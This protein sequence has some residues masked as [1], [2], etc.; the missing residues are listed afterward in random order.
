MVGCDLGQAAVFA[1]IATLP[2]FGVLIGLAAV[3]CVLQTAYGPAR[4]AAVPMLVEE[5]ELISANALL[6]AAS[7]L[8]VAAGP[9][10]GGILFATVGAPT[11]LLV[12]VATFIG[13]ALL[14]RTLP[15]I[16]P[17]ET[18]ERESLLGATATGGRFVWADPVLRA[19]AVS[20]CLLLAFLAVDNV[21]LVF[22]VRDTLSG[23]AAAYGAIEFCWGVGMLIGSFWVLHWAGPRWRPTRLFLLACGLNTFS[24]AAGG[25]APTLPAL[26]AAQVV[27][28]SGNSIDVIATETIIQQRVPRGMI[29]RVYGFTSSATSLGLGIGMAF[30]GFLVDVASPRATFLIAAAGGL[31][32]TLAVAPTMLRAPTVEG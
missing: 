26:G 25:I 17:P 7:N 32:V 22:L 1:A 23:S 21:A 6:G 19:V 31:I 3:A 18:E 12:N 27:G 30:G 10:V 16:P 11:A 13:S 5:D 24:S 28:G 15:A 4:T 8:Y 29:G 20:M 2:P 14:T 9:L